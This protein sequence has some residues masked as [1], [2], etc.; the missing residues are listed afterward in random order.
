MSC[1]HRDELLS[2]MKRRYLMEHLELYSMYDLLHLKQV[3]QMLAKVR[4]IIPSLPT[5][6]F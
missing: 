4:L 2:K 1:K 3:A 5:F 6:L